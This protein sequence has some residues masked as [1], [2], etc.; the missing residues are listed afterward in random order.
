MAKSALT[1]HAGVTVTQSIKNMIVET[2]QIK[3]GKVVKLV[4]SN[5]YVLLASWC[6]I[7]VTASYVKMRFP[8]SISELTSC[9]QIQLM[10]ASNPEGRSTLWGSAWLPPSIMM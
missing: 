8:V 3:Q 7:S 6:V 1:A 5:V 9:E 10:P 4:Q 2:D